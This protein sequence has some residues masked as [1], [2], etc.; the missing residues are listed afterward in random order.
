MLETLPRDL[1]EIADLRL[2]HPSLSLRELAARCRPASTKAS[3][4]RR[5]KRLERLADS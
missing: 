1:R 3:V 5:L 2:R 4:H